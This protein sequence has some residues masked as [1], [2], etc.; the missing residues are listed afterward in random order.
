[1]PDS[2]ADPLEL[3]PAEKRLAASDEQRG[4]REALS[5]MKR[6]YD[7]A[8]EDVRDQKKR[9]AELEKQ[10]AE[11][12]RGIPVPAAHG[13]KLDWESQKRR[14]LAS[15][16]ADHDE[17]ED[18]NE[19]VRAERLKIR[20]VIAQTDAAIAAKNEEIEELKEL[21]KSQSGSIGEVAVGAAAFSD[22]LSHDE[23]V[24]AE[25]DRLR[26]LQQEWEEKLRH[27][28]VELS[29]QRAKLARERADIEE[30]QRQVDEQKAQIADKSETG[31]LCKSGK[32][33]R[34]RW[35]ARLGLKDDD[36]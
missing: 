27:A 8:M 3:C 18:E 28:E 19:E 13:D 30:R 29:V 15:L 1:M 36:A 11:A 33:Q 4:D 16:E 5:D 12:P 22:M 14:L 10:L 34:G 20:E 21:L 6:R 24:L 9:I 31:D 25:R 2:S 35:L 17:D 32:P 26:Q 7:L 23:I